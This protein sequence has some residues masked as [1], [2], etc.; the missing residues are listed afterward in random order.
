MIGRGDCNLTP[1]MPL[2]VGR[3]TGRGYTPRGSFQLCLPVPPDHPSLPVSLPCL[4]LPLPN[5]PLCPALPCPYLILPSAPPPGGSTMQHSG[6]SRQRPLPPPPPCP[7]DPPCFPGGSTTQHSGSS[8]QH[9][10]PPT[11]AA[12]VATA[13]PP[14]HHARLR[15]P[16]P[17]REQQDPL[18]RCPRFMP[19]TCFWL[20]CGRSCSAVMTVSAGTGPPGTVL[21][22]FQI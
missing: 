2:R 20:A 5:S 8:R 18:W 12:T 19:G 11:L 16:P 6:F 17:R 9:P 15:S 10:L 13:A 3:S 1:S 4:T 22:Q 7:H 14:H 21:F